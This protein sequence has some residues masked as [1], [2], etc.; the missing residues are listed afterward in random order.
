L[1]ARYRNHP[2][3]AAADR[4]ALAFHR[5]LAN[6]NYDIASNG[7]RRVLAIIGATDPRVI[8]DVGANCGDWSLAATRA[9]KGATIWAFEVVPATYQQLVANTSTVGAVRAINL[10][11]A[12]VDGTAPVYCT[13]DSGLASCVPGLG[14]ELHGGVSAVITGQFA[15]GDE[16][17][18]SRGIARIDLLKIDVEGF[19]PSVLDGFDRMLGTGAVDAVQFEYGYANAKS[20]YLLR[21]FHHRFERLDM[22]VGK[23]FPDAVDFRPF[24]TTD[25]DFLGPNYLAV[26]RSSRA[27]IDAL[28]G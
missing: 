14:E 9:A 22:V 21:D 23:I 10:G 6:V 2:V 7:E 1:L 19:E 16:F 18:V 3:L 24:R 27:L 25:E 15:S 13:D 4:S 26:R 11:L 28:S 5:A 17:C 20:K 12:A 8:F